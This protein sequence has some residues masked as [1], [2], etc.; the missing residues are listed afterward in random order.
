MTPLFSIILP[1]YNRAY[2][3]WKAVQSVVAQTE[4]RWELIVIDDGSTDSTARLL[5]EFHEPRLRRVAQARRGPSAARNRGLTLARAPFVAYL[6]SD[7]AWR[8]DFLAA[9][10]DEIGRDDDAVLWYCGQVM[11]LWE[12]S[13]EGE[14][15]H[16]RTRPE[17]RAQYD[18]DEVWRLKGPD[19]NCLIHRRAVAA[20]VGGWDEACRWLEDWDFFRPPRREPP[21]SVVGSP[22]LRLLSARSPLGDL[23]AHSS[24]E[25]GPAAEAAPGGRCHDHE[26]RLRGLRPGDA[27]ANGRRIWSEWGACEGRLGGVSLQARL[28]PPAPAGAISAAASVASAARTSASAYTGRWKPGFQASNNSSETITSSPARAPRTAATA[29]IA[30]ASI[31]TT[32]TPAAAWRPMAPTVSR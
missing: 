29:K 25:A 22:R 8:P 1:T 31:S 9:M 6:D 7:N 30:A 13:R 18:L 19:T 4:P 11:T 28:Q 27:L 26:A 10:R 15:R 16:V 21:G 24:G 2:V 14:W 32:A 3:L 5:E 23:Q 17:P 20:E 12:R